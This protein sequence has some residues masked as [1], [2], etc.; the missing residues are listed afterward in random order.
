MERSRGLDGGALKGIAAALMLTDHVG[1]ILLPEVS[2]FGSS[3]GISTVST[4]DSYLAFTS[5]GFT[6]PT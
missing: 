5:S 6:S 2:F 4:P 1:A 3:F